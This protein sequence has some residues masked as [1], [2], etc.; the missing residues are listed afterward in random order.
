MT[1]VAVTQEK[2]R[3]VKLGEITDRRPASIEVGQ[4]M[5]PR[6]WEGKEIGRMKG[7]TGPRSAN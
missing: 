5:I 7:T 1:Q 2:R 6:F 3:K 4:R